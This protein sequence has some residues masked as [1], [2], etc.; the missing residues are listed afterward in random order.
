VTAPRSLGRRHRRLVHA[1]VA[2][3][4]VIAVPGTGGYQLA[5]RLD[6]YPA[7]LAL[8]GLV[9]LSSP[10]ERTV[11]VGS[12]RDARA[13]SGEWS[14]TTGQLTES[15]WPGPVVVVVQ[16]RDD[17]PVT[18]DGGTS[19]RLTVPASRALRLICRDAGPLAMTAARRPDLSKL[20]TAEEVRSHY[21]HG[22]I[23]F[24]LD[25]GTCAG[26]GPT[27][28]DCRVTP[29]VVT[30]GVLPEAYI[31]AVLL[32]AARRRKRFGSRISRRPA[33]S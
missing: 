17:L 21:A 8:N 23:A 7:L 6:S 31:H 9:P 33:P 22:A 19:L 24:V 10:D 20:T 1:A 16:A 25:G 2:D 27:V 26:P 3:D 18:G 14:V 28:V 30:P 32:M 12:P 13:L 4:L 29:P 15:V 11:A 5:A